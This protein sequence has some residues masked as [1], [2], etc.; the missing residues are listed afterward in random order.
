VSDAT[1]IADLIRIVRDIHVSDQVR[2]YAVDLVLATRSSSELR[3]GA[4]PRATLHLIRAARAAA[5]LD[6]RDYVLPDDVQDLAVAVLAHRLLP[7]A[8][9]QIGRRSTEDI[10]ADIVANVPLPDEARARRNA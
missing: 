10:V 7:T 8:E 9:S 6:D 2:Q 3:L 1:E 5:A 4:S